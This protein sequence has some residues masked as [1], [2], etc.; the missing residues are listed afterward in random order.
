MAALVKALESGASYEAIPGLVFRREGAVVANPIDIVED[1]D[2]LPWPARRL[3]PMEAYSSIIALDKAT[4]L[5]SS[6]GCP[7]RCAFCFKQAIDR[8][9]RFRNPV[10]VVDEMEMLGRDYGIQEAMFYDDTITMR[11]E[12]I[13]GICRELIRRGLSIR[14]E[15]PARVNEMDED[16]LKLAKES[17]CMRLRYGVESGDPEI[18][19]LMRKRTDLDTVRR[20]FRQTSAAGIET[21][22]YFMVGYY[23]ETEDSFRKTMSLAHELR[24]DLVMFTVTTPCPGTPL[25][26]QAVGEGLVSADYWSRFVLGERTDRIPYFCS[27]AEERVKRAYRSFYLEPSYV[28]KKLKK[29]NSWASLKKHMQAGLGIL[30][31]NMQPRRKM[32]P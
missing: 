15:S 17:G 6:R 26:D 20:V 7:Y 14:W 11:R 12:H 27:D 22:A 23:R 16:L 30:S 31:F 5:F 28:L 18:L 25:F 4:T 3:L 32:S 1:I 9:A 10:D 21:F 24:P 19:E 2:S 8:K 13:E 29:I